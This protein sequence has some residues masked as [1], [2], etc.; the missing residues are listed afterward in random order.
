MRPSRCRHR[1]VRF[2]ILACTGVPAVNTAMTAACRRLHCRCNGL[3]EFRR[4]DLF[5]DGA[6]LERGLFTERAL[7]AALG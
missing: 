7:E 6:K 2:S 1:K 5:E 4:G 3:V